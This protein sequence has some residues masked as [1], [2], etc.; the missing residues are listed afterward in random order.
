[1][2]PSN[3]ETLKTNISKR[4]FF[5]GVLASF[6]PAILLSSRSSIAKTP[7]VAGEQLPVLENDCSDIDTLRNTEPK[8]ANQTV[9]VQSYYP[10]Q[11]AGSFAA[12]IPST[13]SAPKMRSIEARTPLAGG[14]EFYYDPSDLTSVD[15]GGMVIVTREGKRWK[16]KL[17]GNDKIQAVF[18]GVSP[19]V[20]DNGPLLQ[21]A[22]NFSS[23][24]IVELP[25]GIIT[26]K[27]PVVFNFD[28][29]VKIEG[30]GKKGGTVINVIIGDGYEDM[31]ALHFSGRHDDA[32]VALGYRALSIKNIHLIGNLSRCRGIFIQYQFA[33]RIEQITIEKFDG[34]GLYI[35]KCQD[36][37]FEQVDIFNCGRTSGDRNSLKD[38]FDESKTLDSPIVLTS[39]IAKTDCNYLRFSNC[40]WEDNPVSPVCDFSGGIENYFVNL[41]AEYS[42]YWDIEG[43]KGGTLFKQR[44]GTIKIQG[45]G[46][47][48]IKTL[49]DIEWGEF[50]VESHRCH[51]PKKIKVKRGTN[52]RLTFRD[53]ALDKITAL[54][55]SGE[56]RFEGCTINEVELDYPDGFLSFNSCNVKNNFI[57][58]QSGNGAKISVTGCNIGGG[59][60][61]STSTK[62]ILFDDCFINGNVTFGSEGG[63][64]LN[65]ITKGIFKLSGD[66]CRVV[67]PAT[68]KLVGSEAP[69]KGNYKVGDS[70]VNL[71]PMPGSFIGWVCVK[72]GNPGIW[73][74]YG[75]IES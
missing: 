53:V 12:S 16:R 35:D 67:I 4:F 8:S 18:Y 45:G 36:S 24:R 34:A 5:R 39:S 48:E 22:V 41:H 56:K 55:T 13:Q 11:K 43:T 7:L 50:W 64:W 23:N 42:A 61:V 46:S 54:T 26:I 62:S 28:S 66:N 17:S 3:D 19:L 14:G 6:I 20:E 65:N 37:V 38:T 52:S 68:R 29:G 15:D 63:M 60:N 71:S 59:V 44:K 49:V 47:D 27:T 1:M 32:K 33:M 73:K 74:G 51:P 10:Q 75:Q 70:L 9:V 57:T 72:S 30:S 58:N 69:V 21:A 2:H 40:Q 25:R 31:G